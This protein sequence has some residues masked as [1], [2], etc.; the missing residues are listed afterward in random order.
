MPKKAVDAVHL[1]LSYVPIAQELPD[2]VR[3]LLATETLAAC[4]SEFRPE[5]LLLPGLCK[6]GETW[7]KDPELFALGTFYALSF[8]KVV[9]VYVKK[10]IKG[11]CTHHFDGQSAGVFNYS[12]ETLVSY[13]LLQ[14]YHNCCIKAN[15]SWA[16]YVSKISS[17]YNNTY[18]SSAEEMSFM[19][20]PTFV[21]VNVSD[22]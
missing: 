2:S 16:S 9:P 13:A 11:I 15:M 20:Y 3:E 19:S 17:M 1:P 5:E 22:A 12:G 6:C 14:D 7:R 8:K 4:P 18:C 21:K 10:C